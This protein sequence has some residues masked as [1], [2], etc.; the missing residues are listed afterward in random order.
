VGVTPFKAGAL[1]LIRSTQPKSRTQFF[2]II[3]RIFGAEALRTGP[4]ILIPLS[5]VLCVAGTLSTVQASH[6]TSH[7][8]GQPSLAAADQEVVNQEIV[9]GIDAAVHNRESQLTGYTVQDH[10]AIYR[11]GEANPSA[12]MTVRTDFRKASGKQFFTLSET[13]S[14]LLRSAVIRKVL[15][16]EKEMS[17]PSVRN[18]VLVTSANYELTPEPGTVEHDGRICRIVDLKARRKSTHLFD[19]KAWVDASDF[20]VVRLEGKPTESPSFLAGISSVVREYSKID[21]FPMAVHA[22]AHSHSFLLG[23]MELKVDSTS[24]QLQFDHGNSASGRP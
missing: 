6:G 7:E 5:V 18:S 16:G 3:T 2:G 17:N 20:T 1:T 11:N 9:Q 24:Y 8:T 12:E 4:S 22:E 21:G 14:S 15:A 19:G 10:Y 13:G 23:D